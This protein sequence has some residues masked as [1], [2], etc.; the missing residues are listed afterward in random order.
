MALLHRLRGRGRALRRPSRPVS[1]RPRIAG[2]FSRT[3]WLGLALWL[4]ACNASPE[5]RPD[6]VL[7]EEL[8]LTDRDEVYRITVTG[9]DLELLEPREV[10]I[11]AG[12]FVEFVTTDWR[13]HEV[14]FALDSLSREAR[15][16]LE[17]TDQ[18]ASPPLLQRESRFV[19]W[20]DGA[21]A[22]RYPFVVEGNTSPGRGAVVVVNGR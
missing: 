10:V 17:R 4:G 16:F 21:P 18:V 14:I 22:G 6:E 1:R 13:V 8:G 5:L 12:A 15:E 11:E 9:G 3:G 7:K 2:P 20:F 19:V